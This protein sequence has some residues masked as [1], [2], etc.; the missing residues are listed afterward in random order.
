[1]LAR[2]DIFMTPSISIRSL[3][4]AKEIK[5]LLD[6]CVAKIHIRQL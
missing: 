5:S 6:F 4:T 1:M 3:K 2:K